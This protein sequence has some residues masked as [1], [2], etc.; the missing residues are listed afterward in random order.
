ML[1]AIWEGQQA[2]YASK[3]EISGSK[4]LVTREVDAGLETMRI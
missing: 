3:E 4:A 1:A 2:T